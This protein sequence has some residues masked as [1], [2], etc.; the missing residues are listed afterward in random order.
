MWKLF[1]PVLLSAAASGP[2]WGGANPPCSLQRAAS[3]GQSVWLLCDRKEVY[4]SA[5]AG[6]TW[7]SR[8]LPTEVQLR[9]AWL[10]D[11]RRGFITGDRG[12]L[13]LTEDAGQTWKPIA[14]PSDDNFTSIFFV[15][16][17]GWLAGQTG[18]I[19]HSTDAGLT[20]NAQSSG[21]SQGLESIFFADAEHGWAVGWNAVVLRTTDGGK[22][23]TRVA[24]PSTVYSVDDIHFR[25][26]NNGWA[27]GFNGLIMRSRDGGATWEDLPRS[28]R[29]WYKSVALDAAGRLW[30]TGDHSLLYSE[31]QG[32]SWKSIPVESTLFLH[33]VLTVDGQIWAVGDFGVLRQSPGE[34][35]F[36]ALTTFPE[37][38]RSG[39]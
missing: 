37:Q 38:N 26:A 4:V 18:I 8:T 36:S 3:S 28:G 11:A 9:D 31:D 19:L 32:T 39:G 29:A 16:A 20:W 14:V 1:V 27:V 24:V 30:T 23:W 5:D 15:G 10:S 7:Q 12:L 25:D 22:Q 21:V 35:G 2:A 13:L 34:L 33:H 17:R 6:R